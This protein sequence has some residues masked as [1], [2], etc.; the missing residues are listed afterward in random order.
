MIRRPPRSTRTDTLFP[1]TTLFR[2]PVRDR[3][4]G[5]LAAV[6]GDSVPCQPLHE[7]HRRKVIKVGIMVDVLFKDAEDPGRCLETLAAGGN[8]RDADFLSPAIDVDHPC[9]QIGYAH[10]FALG[11]R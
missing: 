11:I 9:L 5:H 7:R 1:Y 2:S 6:E 4:A 8:G 3:A 10:Q